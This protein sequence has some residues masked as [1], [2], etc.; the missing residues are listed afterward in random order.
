M[1]TSGEGIAWHLPGTNQNA[2]GVCSRDWDDSKKHLATESFRLL[3]D[4]G[5]VYYQ[6]LQTPDTCFDAMDDFGRPN[7]GCTSTQIWTNISTDI[8]NPKYEWIAL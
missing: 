2:A 7:A 4:D 3:D 6:G 8:H 1:D 5:N